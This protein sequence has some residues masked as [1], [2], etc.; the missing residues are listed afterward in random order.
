MVGREIATFHLKA[1]DEDGR[2]KHHCLMRVASAVTLTATTFIRCH[3]IGRSE[4][5]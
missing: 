4:E 1:F 2:T 3:A 5:E